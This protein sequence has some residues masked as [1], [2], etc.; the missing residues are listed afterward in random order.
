M[1]EENRVSNTSESEGSKN[2]TLL[3]AAIKEAAAGLDERHIEKIASLCDVKGLKKVFADADLMR[4][5]ERFISYNLNVSAAARSLYMHRNTMM[6]RID[7]IR[8]A[9]GLD[10]RSFDEAV[11]FRLLYHVY[12]HG[13][14]GLV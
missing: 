4:T 9:T 2:H 13:K 6:Y 3:V 14:S 7:K 10:I 11:A 12:R 8:R 5:A 1:E